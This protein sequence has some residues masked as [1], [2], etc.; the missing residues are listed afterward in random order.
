MSI[1]A[2]SIIV[3]GSAIA[4]GSIL[5]AFAQGWSMSKAMEG[6]SRQ[7]EAS[8]SITGTLIIGLAFIESIAIYVLAICIIILFANP[9]TGPYME[10]EKAKSEVEVLKAEIEKAKL[11]N[12]DKDKIE[13]EKRKLEKA[14]A[15]EKA[16]LE[17]TK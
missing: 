12:I 1:Q 4:V 11:L 15:E 10:A 17:K 14:I 7:P 9:F 6:I 16:K 3:A 5:T 2:I 13:L 8:G